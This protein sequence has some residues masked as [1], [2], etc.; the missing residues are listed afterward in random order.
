MTRPSGDP[1]RHG[2]NAAAIRHRAATLNRVSIMVLC[3]FRDIRTAMLN[4][5]SIMVL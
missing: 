3:A 5:V 4:R 2:M 1:P